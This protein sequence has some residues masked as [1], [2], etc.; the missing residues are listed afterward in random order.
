MAPTFP[1][2]ISEWRPG[3]P[4]EQPPLP[5]WLREKPSQCSQCN[6]GPQC[7]TCSPNPANP[8]NLLVRGRGRPRLDIG[9]YESQ[10]RRLSA[11][12]RPGISASEIRQVDKDLRDLVSETSRVAEPLGIRR[13]EFRWELGWVRSRAMRALEDL[14]PALWCQREFERDGRLSPQRR[15]ALQECLA[16]SLAAA[17]QV[18]IQP[19]T[20]PLPV[21]QAF[22]LAYLER[23]G[24]VPG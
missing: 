21:S 24:L 15:Q 10:L 1:P 16:S 7:A 5:A 8:G 22:S 3:Q 17:R 19:F 2:Q 14:V 9:I 12:L 13:P 11:R 18:L 23:A 4:F 6:P 20:A